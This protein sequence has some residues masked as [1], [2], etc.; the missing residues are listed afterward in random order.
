M[1][2][3]VVSYF[4]PGSKWDAMGSPAIA[5]INPASGPGRVVDQNYVAQIAAAQAR[6]TK[7]LGYLTANY[8]D[9][10]GAQGDG[11]NRLTPAGVKS[12]I[13]KYFSWYPKLD[14]IF[15]D[16][17]DVGATPESL[18]YYEAVEFA[19]PHGKLLVG[20][21][22]MRCD[23]RYLDCFDTLMNFEG[24]PASY[25][26]RKPADWELARPA[27]RQWHCVHSV[28]ESEVD[29]MIAL[30]RSRNVGYLYL[31]GSSYA[32]LPSFYPALVAKVI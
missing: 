12:E 18:A 27:E 20:N 10:G 15:V 31:C 7:V 11:V 26:T 13:A 19:M 6:G 28:L 17:V 32:A 8:R 30:A 22:G 9:A 25:R 3:A 14:G 2:L 5:I 4:Y 16:E 24:T 29:E 1:K 21:P 23:A